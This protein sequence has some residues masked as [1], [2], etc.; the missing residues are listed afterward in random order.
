LLQSSKLSLH[1]ELTVS[2]RMKNLT[3]LKKA[4]TKS[5]TFGKSEISPKNATLSGKKS[6]GK[7]TKFFGG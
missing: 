6:R 2:V 1:L 7:M 5:V 3:F 4:L